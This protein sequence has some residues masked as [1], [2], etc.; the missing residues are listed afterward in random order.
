ME[1]RNLV[2]VICSVEVFHA[3][4]FD[5]DASRATNGSP[6]LSSRAQRSYARTLTCGA[7]IS[8]VTHQFAAP[9]WTASRP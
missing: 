4:G 7:G 1:M 8:A 3:G 2:T 6:A 5:G 9:G